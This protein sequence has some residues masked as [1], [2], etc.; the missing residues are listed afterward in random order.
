[1]TPIISP[2]L[3]VLETATSYEEAIATLAEAFPKMDTKALVQSLVKSA[4][5]ARA[6]GDG[7]DG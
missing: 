5:K 2:V 4:V 3:E 1:M 7:S 6:L